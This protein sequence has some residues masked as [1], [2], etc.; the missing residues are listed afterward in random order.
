MP[1][2]TQISA[3]PRNASRSA[4]KNALSTK[5]AN[6]ALKSPQ[7]AQSASFQKHSASVA[8]NVSNA[9]PFRQ[10]VLSTYQKVLLAKLRI[11]MAQTL[12]SFTDF[13]LLAL[14]KCLG[15]LVKM[16]LASLPHY[17]FLEVTC[18]QI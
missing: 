2:S 17:V 14:V 18:A 10:L 7:Q 8:A 15:L 11:G 4:A 6:S 13:Q 5:S 3:S 16:V 1:L 12:S 9:A